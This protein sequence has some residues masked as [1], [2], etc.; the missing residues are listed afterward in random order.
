M[1]ARP[2]VIF[3]RSQYTVKLDVPNDVFFDFMSLC[4]RVNSM[5]SNGYK[6]TP[7]D[8]NTMAL[9][10]FS[11]RYLGNVQALLNRIEGN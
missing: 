7:D 5:V 2:H 3:F 4:K 8:L 6:I 9:E 11:E 1:K 10:D